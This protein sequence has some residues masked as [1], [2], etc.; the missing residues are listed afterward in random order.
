MIN[1]QN[2]I[3]LVSFNP[4]VGTSIVLQLKEF[5]HERITDKEVRV[6][7]TNIDRYGRKIGKVYYGGKYL[8]EEVVRNG[9]AWWY[10]Y[11]AKN[12]YGLK[13]VEEYAKSKKLGLWK[14]ENPQDPWN[15]RR[16]KRNKSDPKSSSSDSLD[17]VVY[18]T[19]SGKK[20][21][22]RGCRY[23]KSIHASYPLKEAEALG[24]EACSRY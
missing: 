10:K 2:I 15:Y 21:H 13:V 5:V 17:T 3:Q 7:V 1:N 9:D 20:Y 19:K 18:A 8:S 23:L 14:S 24:Y 4:E 11:Y 6:E 12:D 16:G 22:R